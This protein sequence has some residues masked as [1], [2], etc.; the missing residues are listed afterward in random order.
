ML[1]NILNK[2]L[3]NIFSVFNIAV[4]QSIYV[5]MHY[6]SMGVAAWKKNVDSEY[7]SQKILNLIPNFYIC[8]ENY[9]NYQAWCEGSLQTSQEVINRISCILDNLKLNKTKKIK[10]KKTKTK[11]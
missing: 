6:W 7:I 4:P 9:S 10:N 8:G 11:N 2:K 3:N 1:V 5:K